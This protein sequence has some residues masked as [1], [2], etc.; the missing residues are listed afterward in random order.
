[1]EGLTN[2]TTTKVPAGMSL[3]NKIE[4]DGSNFH[5]AKQELMYSLPIFGIPISDEVKTGN[6]FV[7]PEPKRPATIKATRL[8][9]DGNP[10][11]YD[12]PF[13]PA[14]DE[15]GFQ[16]VLKEWRDRNAKYE[17]SKSV[18]WVFL[19]HSLSKPLLNK[20]LADGDRFDTLS[21][22]CDTL[23]LWKLIVRNVVQTGSVG[24]I[25]SKIRAKWQEMKQYDRSTGYVAPLDEFLNKFD[26]VLTQLD[27][28]QSKVSDPDKVMQLILA[29]IPDRYRDVIN[30][31]M[32]NREEITYADFK[33]RLR[34]LEQSGV[35][36][37]IEDYVAQL[38]QAEAAMASAAAYF[39]DKNIGA[40]MHKRKNGN[41]HG[42]GNKATKMSTNFDKVNH[43]KMANEAAVGKTKPM[44]VCFNCGTAGHA[45]YQCKAAKQTCSVCKMAGHATKHHA[46][47]IIHKKKR[48]E[49]NNNKKK[50][51]GDNSK[52]A[53]VATTT[54]GDDTDEQSNVHIVTSY[55]SNGEVHRHYHVPGADGNT[56]GLTEEEYQI[57]NAYIH[58]EAIMM[59][60]MVMM[61]LMSLAM[62]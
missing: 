28:T 24:I 45:S 56:L 36:T 50:S 5:V 54:T 33:E 58:N 57:L 1:M 51:T 40:N 27:G 23:E 35:L 14:I 16:G 37:K 48:E 59:V 41:N 52:R 30:P 22:S 39:V 8:N 18:F 15:P 20:I 53:M 4:A 13:D 31:I 6:K 42:N 2:L 44:V 46:A 3:Q 21:R 17:N 11:E 49:L 47:Y 10:E 25:N 43:D 62:C 26:G 9:A 55:S 32:F 12:R 7:N 38:N 19:L 60:M 29:L 34:S 61:I